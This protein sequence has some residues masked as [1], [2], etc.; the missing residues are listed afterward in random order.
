MVAGRRLRM[1]GSVGGVRLVQV[2]RGGE[3]NGPGEA[4]E[5]AG[6]RAS[7]VQCARSG[8]ALCTHATCLMQCQWHLQG[9]KQG[10]S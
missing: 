2:M 3:R 8:R 9:P 10:A 4:A 1:R 7:A 5:G 6:A